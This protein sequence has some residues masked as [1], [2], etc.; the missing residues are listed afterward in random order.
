MKELISL[1]MSSPVGGV[2]PC[3][4]GK[5]VRIIAI[6]STFATG[7]DGEQISITMGQQGSQIVVAT[8]DAL[9][10]SVVEA[11]FGIGYSN[12]VIPEESVN[13]GTG[14]VSLNGNVES[15]VAGLPDVTWPYAVTLVASSARSTVS[16]SVLYERFDL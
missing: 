14:I 16:M 4:V 12:S 15:V 1:V 2:V 11:N 7:S 8:S 10:A 13:V 6:R 5:Q 9:G 3:P